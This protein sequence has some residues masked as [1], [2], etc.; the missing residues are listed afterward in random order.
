MNT[1]KIIE[2]I[3]EDPTIVDDI[4]GFLNRVNEKNI[5]IT[6][7]TREV[8]VVSQDIISFAE[9]FGGIATEKDVQDAIE[10]M[11]REPFVAQ[12]ENRFKVY[13]DA[14]RS[15]QIRNNDD[16]V[17]QL[18]IMIETVVGKPVTITVNE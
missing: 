7:E 14:L 13:M 15:G 1:S 10:I 18:K 9:Q 8:I 4:P 11:Q 12:A 5:P 2:M 3:N 17:A 6:K 16:I